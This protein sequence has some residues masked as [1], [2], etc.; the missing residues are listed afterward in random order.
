MANVKNADLR[1]CAFCGRN[2][3]EV[4]FLIPARDGK[5]YICDHCIT[6]CADFLDE[7]TAVDNQVEEEALT[8]A[9][10]PRPKDIKAMLDEHVIGQE[11]AKLALSVAVYNHYKRILTLEESEKS[12]GGRRKKKPEKHARVKA[13]F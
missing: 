2:E 3:Q 12:K 11:E 10:L 4:S 8:F 6:L 7:Q 5:T 1:C 13:N 9:T